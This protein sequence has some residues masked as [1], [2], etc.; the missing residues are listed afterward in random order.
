L[1]INL[2][3]RAIDLGKS[4]DHVT[5]SLQISRELDS[6]EGASKRRAA[7]VVKHEGGAGGGDGCRVR[8]WELSEEEGD[9]HRT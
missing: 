5:S 4:I 1:I 9:H 3:F 7:V 6:G 2:I 8:V